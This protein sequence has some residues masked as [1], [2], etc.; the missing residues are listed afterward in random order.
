M[1]A[2]G[3]SPFD[4]FVVIAITRLPFCAF[5]GHGGRGKGSCL[6][7]LGGR[8]NGSGLRRWLGGRGSG[9]GLRLL[10]GRGNGSGLRR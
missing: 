2:F 10:A 5:L 8:G 1:L 4:H 7:W 6:Q 9:R 3:S